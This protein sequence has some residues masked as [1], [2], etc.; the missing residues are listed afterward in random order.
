MATLNASSYTIQSLRCKARDDQ[1]TIGAVTA[2]AP[3]PI[4]APGG[5]ATNQ[6]ATPPI[7]APVTA[8]PISVQPVIPNERATAKKR[9]RALHWKRHSDLDEF[10]SLNNSITGLRATERRLGGCHAA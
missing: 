3:A 1:N 6:P 8:L 7:A 5:P 9:A 10:G 2:P 4:P